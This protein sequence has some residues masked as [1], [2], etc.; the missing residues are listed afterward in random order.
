MTKI[1]VGIIG[2]AGARQLCTALEST[3]RVITA[4]WHSCGSQGGP[5][6]DCILAVGLASGLP[7][8]LRPVLERQ[9]RVRAF[10]VCRDENASAVAELFRMG[11]CDCWL[12]E[13]HADVIVDRLL[14]RVN[15]SATVPIHVN[16]EDLRIRIADAQAR[17][18]PTQFALLAHMIDNRDRW[19]RPSQLV[20]D[21]LKA[22]HTSDT[23]AIRVHIKDIRR[24]FGG[25]AP[26]LQTDRRRARGY[27]F[28]FSPPDASGS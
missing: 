21:V 8:L 9:T 5:R 10:A 22:H 27:R 2:D 17:L 13:T 11:V 1:Q 23:S 6:F 24:A 14:G 18:T 25:N 16:E 28:S 26:W 4:A 12:A 7:E 20:K 3:G 15:P 19:I